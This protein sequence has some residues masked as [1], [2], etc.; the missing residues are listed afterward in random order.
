MDKWGNWKY[1]CM[2]KK[3][4]SN[5]ILFSNKI[6]SKIW[7]NRR[8]GVNGRKGEYRYMRENG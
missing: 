2:R 7:R 3:I 5:R 4:G 1:R 8:N 6:N